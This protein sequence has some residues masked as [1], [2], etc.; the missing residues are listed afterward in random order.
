MTNQ[1]DLA[2]SSQKYPAHSLLRKEERDML[3]ALQVPQ[4]HLSGKYINYSYYIWATSSQLQ[5][6]ALGR[7]QAIK[8]IQ[9]HQV[10]YVCILIFLGISSISKSVHSYNSAFCAF[11]M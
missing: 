9:N 2:E 4:I 8:R 10:N 3:L 7:T 11:H 5:S 6:K 1:D